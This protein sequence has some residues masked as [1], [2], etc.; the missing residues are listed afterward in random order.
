MRRRGGDD[1]HGGERR[2]GGDAFAVM[3]GRL[4]ARDRW[5]LRMLHEH[6]VMT[7]AQLHRLGWA[8]G[9]RQLQ[10]RVRVLR[11]HGVLD[12]FTPLRPYG[13]GS[14]PLH[15]V[16]GP[17]GAQILAAEAGTTVARIGYRGRVRTLGV[18]HRLTLAHDIGVTDLVAGL[19]PDLAAHP[20]AELARWWSARRCARYFGHHTRPDAYLAITTVLDRARTGSAGGGGSVAVGWWEMFLEF[21]TGTE[22]LSQLAGKV[23]GYHALAEDTGV[24]TPVGVWFTRA[25]REPAARRALA[26]AQQ[27]LPVPGRVP[28]LT[29]TPNPTSA[30]VPTGHLARAARPVPGA[31]PGRDAD[32]PPGPDLDWFGGAGARVWLTLHPGAVE[33]VD[34]VTFARSYPRTP[35]L[36][37]DP[38]TEA[39]GSG[40]GGAWDAAMPFP[41]PSPYP[42][43]PEPESGP[44]VSGTTGGRR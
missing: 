28:I 8:P 37:A 15:L 6:T 42:S 35:P 1:A 30:P 29:G 26:D 31:G 19:V 18:A 16:L 38:G 5:L 14:H 9:L 4:T 22:N 17:V 27:A 20:G 3:T 33:R 24:V 10:G 13:Q 40:I 41:A 44:P 32:F 23:A 34:L 12:G 11:G 21:D 43:S 25:A 2:G 7:T 36:P 39:A